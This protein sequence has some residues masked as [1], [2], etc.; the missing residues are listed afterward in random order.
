MEATGAAAL[1]PVCERVM[2]DTRYE[3]QRI[4]EN[5]GRDVFLISARSLKRICELKKED[6]GAA[7][8]AEFH[9]AE[10]FASLMW[11]FK[12]AGTIRS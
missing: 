3:G 6:T 2:N 7:F 8:V 11:R 10:E 5:E 12:Q 4:A 9:T 1:L